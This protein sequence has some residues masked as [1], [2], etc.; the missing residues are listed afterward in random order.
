MKQTG[1][2]MDGDKLPSQ[3]QA[4]GGEADGKDEG[5]QGKAGGKGV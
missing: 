1:I 2:C 3:G 5:R 4:H